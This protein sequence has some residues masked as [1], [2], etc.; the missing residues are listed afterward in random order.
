MTIAATDT[1]TAVDAELKSVLKK[2]RFTGKI[3]STLERW[4]GRRLNP[5]WPISAG[6]RGSTKSFSVRTTKRRLPFPDERIWRRSPP[7]VG[8]QNNNKVGP[9][10]PDPISPRRDRQHAFYAADVERRF[11][12]PSDNPFDNSGGFLFPPPEGDVTFPDLPS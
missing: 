5:N 9:H 7:A 11:S 4:L 10:A 1:L 12:A 2:A 8:V 3:E 6:S